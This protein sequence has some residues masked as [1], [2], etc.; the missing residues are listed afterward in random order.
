MSDTPQSALTP[1]FSRLDSLMLR[2]RQR[3]QRRLHGAK[4]LKTPRLSRR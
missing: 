1:L 3:L 2:D 4:K